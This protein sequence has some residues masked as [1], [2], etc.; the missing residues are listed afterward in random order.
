MS[1][2]SKPYISDIRALDH[3]SGDKPHAG[4]AGATLHKPRTISIIEDTN[5]KP[6]KQRHPRTGPPP[7]DDLHQPAVPLQVTSLDSSSYT[8]ILGDI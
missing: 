2:S 1:L 7:Q 4:I 6:L 5:P 8:S 3:L